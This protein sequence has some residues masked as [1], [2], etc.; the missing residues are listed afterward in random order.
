MT[1]RLSGTMHGLE[2]AGQNFN[3]RDVCLPCLQFA[4]C[5]QPLSGAYPSE[6]H[7]SVSQI[8]KDHAIAYEK[9]SDEQKSMDSL[10]CCLL[11]AGKKSYMH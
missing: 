11:W 2:N 7:G 1:G 4:E 8:H 9:V 3:Y 5:V 6:K 10:L